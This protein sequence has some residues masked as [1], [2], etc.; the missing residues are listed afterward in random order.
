MASEVDQGTVFKIF[1]PAETGPEAVRLPDKPGGKAADLLLKGA[2][3]ILVVEDESLVRQGVVRILRMAGYR[4]VEAAN[5]NEALSLWPKYRREIALLFTDMIMPE[6]IT[7]MELAER[8]R[9]EKP[10][11]KVIVSS[12]Y[13]MEMVSRGVPTD[14]GIV[15]LPKPYDMR[16][17]GTMVRGCLDGVGQG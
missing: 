3:T 15:Y 8:L 10:E 2:E 13:S 12:G 14:A 4:V 7:G 11:L 1:F 17:L 5:G 6:S 9:Q 16:A